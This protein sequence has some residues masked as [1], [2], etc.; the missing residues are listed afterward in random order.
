M[1]YQQ[2]QRS[3][4][5]TQN[6]WN[7]DGKRSSKMYGKVIFSIGFIFLLVFSYSI[8]IG[9]LDFRSYFLPGLQQLPIGAVSVCAT[10]PPLKVYMYELPRRFHVGM[11]DHKSK[12]DDDVPVTADNLPRW[13][14][15][16][17]IKKQHSVEYWLMASLLYDG[18][19]EEREV[20]RVLD[21]EAADAFFVPFFSSL[22]FNTHGH[23]M[24]DPETEKDR[25][26]QVILSFIQQ[27]TFIS[28][29]FF[30]NSNWALSFDIVCVQQ[31]Q[32][33]KRRESKQPSQWCQLLGTKS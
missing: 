18:G 20:V 10:G 27:V 14:K 29:R 8:F 31:L 23:N 9:T 28:Q 21:P 24:T 17:G 7:G 16:V 15:N 25:Q 26:L 30:I 13:P 32:K 5:D 33:L 4:N 11:M 12:I 2:L 19:K 6:N 22:S 3:K 1:T